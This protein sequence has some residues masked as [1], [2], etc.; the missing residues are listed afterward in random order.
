MSIY[1]EIRTDLW[2]LASN[3][4]R[5]T[6]KKLEL[7]VYSNIVNRMEHLCNDYNECSIFLEDMSSTIKEIKEK[8]GDLKRADIRAMKKVRRDVESYLEDEHDLIRKGKYMFR[9]M[10]AGAGVGAVIGYFFMSLIS[11]GVLLGAIV[12]IGIGTKFDRDAKNEGIQI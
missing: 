5:H 2:E 11:A 10:T 3:L 9:Y 8:E 4:D 6:R 1:K 12:G 7:Q